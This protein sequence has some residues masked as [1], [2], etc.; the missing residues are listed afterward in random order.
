MKTIT[1]DFLV[2]GSGIAGLSAA[3]HLGR[4]G[5]TLVL[6]KGDVKEGST[7][8]AQGGIAVA[9]QEDDTTSYH[10][11]DTLNAGDGFCNEAAVRCLVEEG[12]ARVQELIQLGAQFDKSG[13]DFDFTREGAHGH[14]RILHA[15][16]A[17][18][19]EIEKTLGNAVLRDPAVRFYPQSSVLKLAIQDGQCVGCYGVHRGELTLFL[20]KATV[21]ASG[22]CGQLFSLNTNPPVAT[23][24]GIALAYRAG[25]SIV[26][27]EFV[28]FHPTTLY[29]G[30]K[31]PI[32]LFLISEAVRGEGAVLRNIQGERF[33]PGY[34]P[35]A[36]LASRDVVSRAIFAEMQRTN[37]PHVYLD[38]SGL[39]F[40]V[41]KRFPT[42][43]KRC[44]DARI[45]ITRDFIP[46][47]PAA[48]YHMGGVC[49]DIQ[50]RTTI[51]RLYVAGE[52]SSF[53]V[54]G[55]NRLASNSLLD[56]L[57]FGFRAAEDARLQPS[58]PNLDLT[59]PHFDDN[60]ATPI[61][62]FLTAKALVRD[63]MWRHGGIIRSESGL[64]QALAV[65]GQLDW[66]KQLTPLKPELAEITAMVW[67]A[68]ALLKGALLRQES[69]GAHFRE[70]FPQKEAAWHK[71]IVQ[72][73]GI[74]A[75]EPV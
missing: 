20:A 1:T 63:V 48:H 24:D 72:Q 6:T 58:L 13:D 43:Y 52:V 30:D 12:P 51:P 61:P 73:N 11:Q 66:I 44:L 29:L 37:S 57:V 7:Q 34:H 15:G 54:H 17:T 8:Y 36:E 65:L 46:V 70:D 56:G 22:G 74:T 60:T 67:A 33:M 31:R 21:L 40:D 59:P 4:F 38:L 68:E 50:G 45:D 64:Q 35:D 42:I 10:F 3:H 41:A 39:S 53:G 49:C 14:R 55:A 26:D 18:G 25:A 16:D 75:F 32:S 28:Q 71:R 9:L 19:K 23:G 47:A 5:T 2:V 69:R 27:M 62:Q